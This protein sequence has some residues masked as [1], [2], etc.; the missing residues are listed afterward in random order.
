MAC[1]SCCIKCYVLWKLS[2]CTSGAIRSW[3]KKGSFSERIRTLSP[4]RC[5]S[6]C[7]Y[8]YIPD[9]NSLLDKVT[10]NIK[11]DRN[12]S[13]PH[14]ELGQLKYDGT[15]SITIQNLWSSCTSWHQNVGPSQSFV[16]EKLL[17]NLQG[18]AF[19]QY[20]VLIAVPVFP[21]IN[22][23]DITCLNGAN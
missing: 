22:N 14:S 16:R 18:W 11:H 19:V 23:F 17:Q 10:V 13:C 21:Q 5:L 1:V 7:L 4:V 15:V 3:R 12:F 2:F 8:V 20:Y 9:W 6:V